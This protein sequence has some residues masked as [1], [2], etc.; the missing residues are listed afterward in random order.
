MRSLNEVNLT[1]ENYQQYLPIVPLAF[2]YAE[3]GACGCPCQVIIVDNDKR[4]YYFYTYELKEEIA[5]EVLP[6]IFECEFGWFGH[7]NAAN[8]WHGF[9]LGMGNHL[10]VCDTIFHEFNS[11]AEK[12]ENPGILYQEWINIIVDGHLMTTEFG[13]IQTALD[14]IGVE[15][16]DFFAHQLHVY[17]PPTRS[18]SRHRTHLPHNDWLCYDWT[19]AAKTTRGAIGVLRGIHTRLGTN[20]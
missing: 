11:I 14:Y 2:S 4:V 7:D 19:S 12:I 5:R 20:W 17:T 18:Y 13:E 15:P 8:G 1:E 3:G 10:M 9:Y 16:S 6:A